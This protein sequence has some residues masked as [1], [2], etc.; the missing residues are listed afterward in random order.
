MPKQVLPTVQ[1]DTPQVKP[2]GFLAYPAVAD[3]VDLPELTFRKNRDEEAFILLPTPGR[4]LSVQ[5]PAAEADQVKSFAERRLK[6]MVLLLW[7]EGLDSDLTV[8]I[9]A[10]RAALMKIRQEGAKR[11]V[12]AH[13]NLFFPYFHQIKE[14]PIAHSEILDLFSEAVFR[15]LALAMKHPGAAK[16]EVRSLAVD[17]YR[18]QPAFLLASLDIFNKP[19]IYHIRPEV[20][21]LNRISA[22]N[23]AHRLEI[24]P[25]AAAADPHLSSEFLMEVTG[26]IH[27]IVKNYAFRYVDYLWTQRYRIAG[28]NRSDAELVAR[29]GRDLVINPYPLVGQAGWKPVLYLRLG[30]AI[31]LAI[32]QAAGGDERK[33]TK[34]LA[35]L[36]TWKRYLSFEEVPEQ[37]SVQAFCGLSP[38]PEEGENRCLLE[39][40]T[41]RENRERIDEFIMLMDYSAPETFMERLKV[42]NEPRYGDRGGAYY[43][44]LE[45][46]VRSLNTTLMRNNIS[47]SQLIE[48]LRCD[49]VDYLQLVNLLRT[50]RLGKRSVADVDDWLL[51][52]TLLY[53]LINAPRVFKNDY[54][55]LLKVLTKVNKSLIVYAWTL[56]LSHDVRQEWVN[57]Y[58]A[59]LI[60]DI[61]VFDR[62][63]IY[64]IVADPLECLEAEAVTG[65]LL[66]WASLSPEEWQ[67]IVRGALSHLPRHLLTQL[68][69]KTA[70]DVDALIPVMTTRA[71]GLIGFNL[72]Q[73]YRWGS[74]GDACTEQIRSRFP[75]LL[76]KAKKAIR[77][78]KTN[79][80][81]AMLLLALAQILS[82]VRDG[83]AGNLEIP[84]EDGQAVLNLI[85]QCLA[86]DQSHFVMMV[87]G[88]AAGYTGNIDGWILRQ[89]DALLARYGG[90]DR[91]VLRSVV[92][93]DV[94]LLLERAL[95]TA[96]VGEESALLAKIQRLLLGVDPVVSDQA[97]TFLWTMADRYGI[98]TPDTALK[99]RDIRGLV[100]EL[101]RLSR[102]KTAP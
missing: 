77:P 96:R 87:G 37:Q 15:Y 13:W 29:E 7:P 11:I 18:A 95:L 94:E 97:N 28:G 24:D 53:D 12:E 78:E 30:Y 14:L 69:V 23:D 80:G 25:S 90:G 60:V 62:V 54:K 85:Q 46:G 61:F 58:I 92:Q 66:N 3:D 2:D 6:K 33:E 41:G 42:L 35:M 40:M 86:W 83:F 47:Y 55:M 16:E 70:N 43:E 48:I 22:A 101:L 36:K 65:Y 59:R 19:A 82:D 73:A 64:E 8:R 81:G 9:I 57:A 100:L 91:V 68:S 26:F 71:S 21:W 89:F 63:K 34:Y 72:H 74:I 31:M 51:L 88:I 44:Q 79:L 45:N 20:I 4:R 39:C 5:R 27:K 1:K 56:I 102:T 75:E 67:S 76:E 99:R 49:Q 52:R 10:R 93:F 50:G 84:K 98:P 17:A 32:L 38:N